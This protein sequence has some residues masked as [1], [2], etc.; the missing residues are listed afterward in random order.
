[1][2]GPSLYEGLDLKD[3]E[4]R[5]NIVIKAPYLAM[6]EYAKKKMKRYPDW[7]YN[8]CLQKLEQAIGRTNRHKDDWSVVYLLDNSL[9]KL[10]LSLNKTFIDR[11]QYKKL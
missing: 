10:V 4:G 1:L 2:V 11:L 9:K 5:F 6:S 3:D 7:Y 8:N